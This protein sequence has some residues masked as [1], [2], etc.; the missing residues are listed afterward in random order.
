M[1]EQT[2]GSGWG[3]GVFFLYGG[4]VVFMLALVFFVSYHD[5]E[6]VDDNYYQQEL[7]YQDQIDRVNRTRQ[8]DGQMLVTYDR[9]SGMVLIDYPVESVG[10]TLTGTVTMVR[11]SN[12]ELD[13]EFPVSVDSLGRQYI[14]ATQMTKGLWRTKVFWVNGTED[15]FS[16]HV[17][18]IE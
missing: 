3:K 12:S 10:V 17:L 5:I 1:S 13:T 8:L 15:Y 7:A 2:K 9:P 16:E 6:L 11:P 4:F 14:D 18:I